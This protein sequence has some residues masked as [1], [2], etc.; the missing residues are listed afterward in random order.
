MVL[1]ALVTPCISPG[2]VPFL[3]LSL[4]LIVYVLSVSLGPGTAC[5]LHGTDP[6]SQVSNTDSL[7]P[8]S[9]TRLPS[10]ARSMCRP[11]HQHCAGRATN[12]I[13]HAQVQGERQQRT[14]GERATDR[15]QA[16]AAAWGRTQ[17]PLDVCS[18]VEAFGESNT[19]GEFRPQFTW[20]Q[21][22]RERGSVDLSLP[23]SVSL[24]VCLPLSVCPLFLSPLYY[25][26]KF[27]THKPDTVWRKAQAGPARLDSAG[28]ASQPS[29]VRQ[30]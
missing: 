1:S 19:H 23:P 27:K 30:T 21:Q 20:L 16:W 8:N 2:P 15:T 3:C 5:P 10:S 14:P 13:I 6:Q 25:T 9:G 4:T 22:I 12:S 18:Q 28:L 11:Y 26:G 17:G 24:S 29:P 7:R